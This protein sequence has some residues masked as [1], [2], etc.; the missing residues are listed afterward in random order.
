MNGAVWEYHFCMWL[1]LI[2]Y[3]FELDCYNFRILY[4]IPM[5][6]TIKIPIKIPISVK[7]KGSQMYYYR[8]Q[9][10]T[11]EGSSERNEGGNL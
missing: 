10:P 9:L 2:W 5:E 6:T 1:M 3:Q 4:E 7:W 11:N 8:N